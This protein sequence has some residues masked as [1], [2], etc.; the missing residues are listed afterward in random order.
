MSSTPQSEDRIMPTYLSRP[1]PSTGST[2]PG[3]PFEHSP[4]EP[5]P[6]FPPL[7]RK[8]AVLT[9]PAESG[10]RFSW[11]M[12]TPPRSASPEPEPVPRLLSFQAPPLPY[13]CTLQ[14]SSI[15]HN[16]AA[17]DA[18][19]QHMPLVPWDPPFTPFSILP[20]PPSA[21]TPYIPATLL[22]HDRAPS[23][24]PMSPDPIDV[25]DHL[26]VVQNISYCVAKHCPLQVVSMQYPFWSDEKSERADGF[27]SGVGGQVCTKHH[28][29]LSEAVAE[30]WYTWYVPDFTLCMSPS[31]TPRPY[32]MGD[33]GGW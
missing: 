11:Q 16:L 26:E 33:D 21:Y 9:L 24:N 25:A 17:I 28:D 22:P 10:V 27:G 14:Q 3:T 23:H 2:R 32:Q 1:R 15:Q 4:S 18:L 29:E 30:M 13:D 20:T 19:R 5:S 7:T 12:I 6:T 8:P 31:G